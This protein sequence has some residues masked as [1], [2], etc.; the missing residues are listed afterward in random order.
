M[1][2]PQRLVERIGDMTLRHCIRDGV[3]GFVLSKCS[4]NTSLF[5]DYDVDDHNDC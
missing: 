5:Y 3:E 2:L 4:I 1:H